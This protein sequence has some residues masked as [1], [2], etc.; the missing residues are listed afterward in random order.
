MNQLLTGRVNWLRRWLHR[1]VSDFDGAGSAL[2]QMGAAVTALVA[3]SWLAATF[4][5]RPV[6]YTV[7]CC[8]VLAALELGLWLARKLLRRLL[9]HDLA[10]LLSLGMLGGSAAYTV[11]QGAG[12][13]WTYRV[14][15]FSAL[16]AAALWLLA[17]SWWGILRRRVTPLTVSA[18]LLSTGTTALLG[19]F[20]FTSGFADQDI[21]RYLALNQNRDARLTA[22]EPSLGPGPH[23][24]AVVDYGPGQEVEAGTVD[25]S[26]YMSRD[27]GGLVGNFVD[28]YWDYDLSQVPMEGRVW[29]PADGEACPVLF[30]AHGNHEI[31]TDSYLGY[32]TWGNTWPPTAMWW[33]R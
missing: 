27:T 23:P 3:G 22:L 31:S 21:R 32:A 25:L 9:G 16:T 1:M 11:M 18:A 20:L 28:V 24:T 17:A 8:A 13:G 26:A 5:P 29:Y 33:Y 2:C 4:W 15:L 14:W 7:L 12:E 10:W 6:G 19:V 30:I